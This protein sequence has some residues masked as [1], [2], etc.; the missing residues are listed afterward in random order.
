M[1]T[2]NG[3]CDRQQDLS[4]ILRRN[5]RVRALELQRPP[6]RGACETEW[7]AAPGEAVSA[8][9]RKAEFLTFAK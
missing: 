2:M 9:L 8:F 4:A 1:A 6:K 5:R 7:C 3:I